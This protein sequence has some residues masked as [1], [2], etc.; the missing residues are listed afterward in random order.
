MGVGLGGRGAANL[1]VLVW[2]LLENGSWCVPTLATWKVM[3]LYK[4]ARR[5]WARRQG[6]GTGWFNVLPSSD[7][8]AWGLSN[9]DA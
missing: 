4:W 7:D 6:V 9:E 5:E 2:E 1:D 3:S 8:S